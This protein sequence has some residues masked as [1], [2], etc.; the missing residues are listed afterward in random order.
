[1][2]N[3]LDFTENIRKSIYRNISQYNEKISQYTAIRFSCIVTPLL[4][5]HI[6]SG[7]GGR[8]LQPACLVRVTILL[9][10]PFLPLLFSSHKSS[11]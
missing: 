7:I 9:L 3:S 11:V 2:T 10:L 1:M 6:S 5:T 4:V 8:D